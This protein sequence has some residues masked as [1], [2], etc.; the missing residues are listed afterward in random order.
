MRLTFLFCFLCGCGS[1]F[2]SQPTAV[3]PLPIKIGGLKDSSIDVAV[4]L[5]IEKKKHG[6]YRS[7][8]ELRGTIL[9]T[10][11]DDVPIPVKPTGFQ[12]GVRLRW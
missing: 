1:A 4:P 7:P 2:R 3:E 5:L 10:S 9:L 12:V 6:G 11:P 8:V